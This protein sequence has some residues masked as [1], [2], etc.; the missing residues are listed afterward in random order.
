[1]SLAAALHSY[2]TVRSVRRFANRRED[3]LAWQARRL[4][5]WLRNDIQKVEAFQ[6]LTGGVPVLESLP[7]ME[8]SHLM[9]D[10]SRYNVA[11]VTNEEGWSAFEGSRRIGNLIAGAST[12]TSGNRGLFVISEQERFAWLGAVLAKALPDFWRHR[13]RV[14]VLLPVNTPLYTSA[15]RTRVLTLRF[16]DTNEPLADHRTALHV[17]N[18]T[19]LIAPPRILRQIAEMDLRFSPRRV[20]SCAEKLESFDRQPIE[21]VFRVPL[22][23]IYMATEGL[24][25]VTCAHGRLHLTE[26]CMH[27]SFEEKGGGLCLP[28]I[29]DFSRKTQIMARYRLNDLLR[30]CSRRCSCGSPLQV[31]DEI[32]GREDDIFYLGN[33]DGHLVELTP[34]ILRNTIVDADRCI[35]DFKLV[36]TACNQLIL[37][38][39]SSVPLPV[40]ERARDH[41]VLLLQR[42]GVPRVDLRLADFVPD[43]SRKL[44]R[45]M[46]QWR[47]SGGDPLR[48]DSF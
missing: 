15:D 37:H 29:S 8:K 32:V 13:D 24:L 42:H 44:R 19:V 20:F 5:R 25:A 36:Q 18:P 45:V 10:F 1:M 41:L 38:L 34:D 31:V 16:F 12:G 39:P 21:T 6:D 4:E 23:E 35:L 27:F 7:I 2:L 30:L 26:D 46:R 9:A 28:I 40:R 48:R 3:F 14:A 22:Q 33:E 47:R 11:R 43:P 17:F